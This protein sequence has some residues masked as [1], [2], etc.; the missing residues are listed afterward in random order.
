MNWRKVVLV[1][2]FAYVGITGAIR[3]RHTDD[4]PT[5]VGVLLAFTLLA[6]LAATA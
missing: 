3:R 5:T 1:A 4:M 6:V 2:F